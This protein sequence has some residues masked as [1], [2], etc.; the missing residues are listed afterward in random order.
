MKGPDDLLDSK[1]LESRFRRRAVARGTIAGD[2]YYEDDEGRR[3]PS[4]TT[5]T[6]QIDF[7]AFP[8]DYPLFESRWPLRRW[9]RSTSRWRVK[10][11][12]KRQL[13]ILAHYAITSQMD[14]TTPD[15]TADARAEL[16]SPSADEVQGYS[17]Q[18]LFEVLRDYDD[19]AL[20]ATGWEYEEYPAEQPLLDVATRDADKIARLWRTTIRPELNLDPDDVW[21]GELK[22]VRHLEET[23]W[24]P[25]GYGGQIDIIAELRQKTRAVDLKTG[26]PVMEYKMQATAYQ[27][28][29]PDI[30]E[31]ALIHVSPTGEWGVE[32]SEDW[33]QESLWHQFRAELVFADTHDIFDF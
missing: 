16:I 6:G 7:S 29:I 27:Y 1:W 18:K 24:P 8:E 5:I 15:D 17:K 22:F 33:P 26:S 12:Y 28:G 31:A 9:K 20:D 32:W 11:W 19:V 4:T 10:R 30:E 23:G 2:R 25:L 21:R 14:I 13:G 3:F